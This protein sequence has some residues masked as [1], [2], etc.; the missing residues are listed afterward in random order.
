MSPSRHVNTSPAP[1]RP[2]QGRPE[3]R[4]RESAGSP[5]G[6][7]AKTARK[8]SKAEDDDSEKPETEWSKALQTANLV[9]DESVVS[10]VHGAGGLV[11]MPDLG[12]IM[13]VSG[14]PSKTAQLCEDL[15]NSPVLTRKGIKQ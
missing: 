7:Y 6:T 10:P 9:T 8:G 1:G 2:Q 12:A 15:T 4:G 3:K 14:T 5:A 13:S 11:R